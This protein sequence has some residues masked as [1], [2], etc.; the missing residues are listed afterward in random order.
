M[1]KLGL[2]TLAG[3]QFKLTSSA[4]IKAEERFGYVKTP[5]HTLPA[6]SG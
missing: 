5:E 3:A 6:P 4:S 2:E 1:A